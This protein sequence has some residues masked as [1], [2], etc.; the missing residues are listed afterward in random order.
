[1][2]QD[3]KDFAAVMMVIVISAGSLLVLAAGAYYAFTRSKRA[4][5]LPQQGFDDQLTQLQRSVDAVALEVE[6]I[7][8]NQRF[9]TRLLAQGGDREIGAPR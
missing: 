6:R 8:E 9:T 5:Q 7:A 2:S 1:M 4:A 3:V